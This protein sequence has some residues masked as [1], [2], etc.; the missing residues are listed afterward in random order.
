[1][2]SRRVYHNSISWLS[3]SLLLLVVAQPGVALAHT[4]KPP[5]PRTLLYDWSVEPA[6]L[7]G[8]AFAIWAYA[9]GLRA[10]WGRA[11]V[12]HGIR[13][14]QVMAFAAGLVALFVAL[15][16]PLDAL[17]AALFS[18]HMVQHLLLILVAA[19]LLVLGMPLVTFVWALPRA[20][21]HRLGGWGHR[22]RLRKAWRLLTQPMIAW[23]I[24]VSTLWIWHLPALFQATL[25]N[26]AI[27]ALEHMSFLLTALL[28]WWTVIH[29][30]G[31]RGMGY[32]SALLSLFAATL[33]GSVL[34]ALMTFAATPWYPAY[35]ASTAAWRLTPLE[36]QQLAGLIMWIPA[37]VLYL[38][39]VAALFVAWFSALEREMRRR[40]DQPPAHQPGPR[41][42]TNIQLVE[43][44]Y[45]PLVPSPAGIR[46][47][48]RRHR[49]RRVTRL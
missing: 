36:D 4:G 39:A 17:G 1:M 12:A 11:G 33:Q 41:L 43:A 27:H 44:P 18:A 15:V 31:R 28:F 29:P 32:G 30:A 14:A 42:P 37:S 24:H 46:R 16:S 8:L 48:F 35:A 20:W 10:L 2:N 47:F 3:L 6:V 40:E 26:D 49:M 34:G 23:V 9:R 13:R 7:F 38:L 25:H 45:N 19:P 5:T 21:R 22:S